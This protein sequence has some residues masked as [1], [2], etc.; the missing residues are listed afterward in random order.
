[1]KGPQQIDGAA[2]PNATSLIV[3][4]ELVMTFQDQDL[5]DLKKA[6]VLFVLV[7]NPDDQFPEV[8]TV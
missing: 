7:I 8:L 4:Q 1:M 5:N 3:F 6:K 2:T